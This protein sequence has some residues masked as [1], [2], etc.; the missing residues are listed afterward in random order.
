MV[1]LILYIIIYYL[2]WLDKHSL[3]HMFN[4]LDANVSYL[5]FHRFKVVSRY[6]DPQL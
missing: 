4:H 2:T 1:Y 6:R 5:N 3:W